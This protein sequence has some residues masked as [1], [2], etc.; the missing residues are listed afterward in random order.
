MNFFN[1]RL[2]YVF[3]LLMILVILGFG[4]AFWYRANHPYN[5]ID[6]TKSQPTVRQPPVFH[7]DD[8]VTVEALFTNNED[9]NVT[10][11]AKV[12]WEIK[13]PSDGAISPDSKRVFQFE[14]N[15]VLNPG[16]TEM[17]FDNSPPDEVRSLTARLF[18]EGLK[19]VTWEINGT[20]RVVE[21][22]VSDEEF[23]HTQ[24]FTYY[25]NSDKLPKFKSS[26][27]LSCEAMEKKARESNKNTQKNTEITVSSED[28]ATV[29]APSQ[30]SLQPQAKYQTK[31]STPEEPEEEPEIETRISPLSGE[32]EYRY[33]GDTGWRLCTPA[34]CS[35]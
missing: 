30:P 12:Y 18:S 31:P 6:F 33:S 24:E 17:S 16:C 9:E 7:L 14:F 10:L 5:P 15:R 32:L 25:H 8:V 29:F 28:I 4:G 3:A 34:V 20:N 35:P 2:R 23:F 27:K 1:R 21:P 26:P 13:K 11:N 22:K 19:T